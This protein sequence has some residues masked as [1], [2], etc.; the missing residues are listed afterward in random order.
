M[1]TT[2]VSHFLQ[3]AV[4]LCVLVLYVWL[5][6]HKYVRVYLYSYS[7]LHF[8]CDSWYML[9]SAWRYM[10][11]LNT[12]ASWRICVCL[13]IQLCAFL[14]WLFS[15]MWLFLH[16]I[17]VVRFAMHVQYISVIMW[18]YRVLRAA[19]MHYLSL[20]SHVH[21]T[22]CWLSTVRNI[23]FFIESVSSVKHKY[24]FNSLLP[25]CTFVQ[26]HNTPILAHHLDT[27]LVTAVHW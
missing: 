1:W 14:R 13:S 23:Y 4:C 16:S 6:M 12:S 21:T 26:E 7:T 18:L 2:A 8:L 3:D 20:S 10:G 9:V 25:R 5:C 24:H 15:C 22:K 17:H 11:L 27:H 19:G